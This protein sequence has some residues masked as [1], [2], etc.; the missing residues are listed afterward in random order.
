MQ[1]PTFGQGEGRIRGKGEWGSG[2]WEKFELE[3]RLGK[4]SLKSIF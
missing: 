2:M 4:F 1:A 3:E